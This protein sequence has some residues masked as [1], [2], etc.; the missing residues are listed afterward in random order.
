MKI[1][2]T[3]SLGNIS[4]PLAK[5]LIAAGHQVTI[6]SSKAD[7]AA[8]IE[9]LGATPAIGSVSDIDFLTK[10]FTGADVVYTM[11][12]PNF[13]V[14][15]YRKYIAETGEKYAQAIQKAGVKKVVNLSSIGAHLD[16]G[17]GPIAGLHD[18]ENI[19]AGLDG[20]AVKH[21]R[22]GFFYVNFFHDIPMIKNAGFMGSNYSSDTNLVMVHPDDIADAAAEEIQASFTGKSVRYVT[23]A[24]HPISDVVKT[25]GTA[26]GKPDL[27]WME[28]T[29]EQALDGMLKAGFPKPIASMYVEMGTAVRSGILFEH[30]YTNKPA[31]QGKTKLEDFA[32]EF[33]TL[34]NN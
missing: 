26:I 18:V 21:L 4:K 14:S 16:G 2:L 20:V 23:S 32:N 19:F 6:I 5:K 22:A 33:A 30:Y 25:L 24:E 1:T 7:K 9:A 17:T 15:D 28:F 3:G 13:G 8:E 34:F 29:D 11:V 31:A 10:A 12:P 27:K